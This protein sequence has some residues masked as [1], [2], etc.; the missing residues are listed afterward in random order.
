MKKLVAAA[1]VAA[2]LFI[3]GPGEAL[4]TVCFN[5]NKPDGAGNFGDVIVDFTDPTGAS[6]TIPTNP[7]GQ[8][9]GGFVDVYADVDGDGTADFKLIDDTFVLNA[10]QPSSGNAPGLGAPGEPE[11][12]EGAHSAAGCGQGVDHASCGP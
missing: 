11:L 8:I 4:A 7:G 2:A 3:A 5:A 1:L 6:D 12:P 10:G 9:A